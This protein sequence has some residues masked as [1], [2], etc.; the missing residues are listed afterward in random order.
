MTAERAP[1]RVPWL[2]DA[3]GDAAADLR[4]QAALELGEGRHEVAA[5]LLVARFGRESDFQVREVLT[6]AALRMPDASLPRVRQA[7]GSCRW[8]ARLQATHTLSKLGLREDGTRL[9][10][11]VSDPVDAVA[12][13]AY[14]A[15]A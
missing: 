7:L 13:R 15:A 6:W 11:L 14:W 2:V 12:S 1:T 10:R 9:M 8:L 4:L 5:E 3:L